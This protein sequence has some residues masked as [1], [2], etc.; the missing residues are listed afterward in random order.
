MGQRPVTRQRQGRA[1]AG[2]L[3][4]AAIAAGVWLGAQ[5]NERSQRD[6]Q[7]VGATKT[8]RLFGPR[9]VTAGVLR[10]PGTPEIVESM[11][12]RLRMIEDG[13]AA[14]SIRI[15]HPAG[16]RSEVVTA[17][18]FHDGQYWSDEIPG[19]GA[20]VTFTTPPAGARVE[21]DAY[22]VQIG[23]PQPQGIIGDDNSRP[24]TDQ[25]V[26][27]KVKP[28]A[29]SVAR[30]KFMTPKG[31]DACTGFLVGA[32][33]LFTNYHCI[34]TEAHAASARVEF[35]VD[36]A[37]SPA[38]MFHVAKIE[39]LDRP[40]DY[41]LLQLTKDATA[42]GRLY[43]AGSASSGQRLFLVQH[44][45]GGSK[46]VAFPPVCSVGRPSHAG[47]GGAFNDFGHFCDTLNSSSGS[48]IMDATSGGVI[49][50]H[51]WNY[52]PGSIELENQAIHMRLVM[53][54]L[55]AKVTSTDPKKKLAQA[56]FDEVRRTGP[57]GGV[58]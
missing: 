10:V 44:P 26:P 19:G 25:A 42:F 52:L 30:V 3:A 46:R 37:A 14:W 54:S 41:S 7:N 49:G 39:A 15:S 28:W 29:R 8:L 2:L 58:Q 43:I 11:R 24:I 32:R 48:P 22:A 27:A 35:G 36:S 56:T 47:V 40:L 13:S 6:E 9:Q 5:Q 45:R 17:A 38:T 31:E 34:S 21:V 20:H 18:S 1:A 51:H 55:A 57:T 50:L 12:V 33:L 53:D 4:I 16:T 23:A